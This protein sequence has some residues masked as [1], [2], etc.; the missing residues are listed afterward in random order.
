MA[1]GVPK[2]PKIPEEE[3]TPLVVNLIELIHLQHEQIQGLKDE[4]ARL[5]KQ[6]T[7]PKLRPSAL[8]KKGSEKKKKGKRPGSS[9]RSKLESLDIHEMITIS[10]EEPIPEGSRLKDHRTYTVQDLIL[11]PHNTVSE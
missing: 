5:K 4:I 7:K 6:K 3:R 11:K 9:K 2:L 1:E 10:P 8:V